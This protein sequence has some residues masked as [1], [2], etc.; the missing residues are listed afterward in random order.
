[1]PYINWSTTGLV[2]SLFGGEVFFRKRG[3]P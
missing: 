1:M 3:G 2:V